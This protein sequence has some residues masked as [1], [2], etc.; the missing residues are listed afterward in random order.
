[1]PYEPRLWQ[2]FVFICLQGITFA[3][4]DRSHASQGT[5][6]MPAITQVYLPA[7]PSIRKR[8]GALHVSLPL[9]LLPIRY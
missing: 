3:S 7:S 1:M 2:T 9:Q 4:Q 5:E 8:F 6:R